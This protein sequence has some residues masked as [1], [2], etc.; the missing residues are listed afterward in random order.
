MDLY[1]MMMICYDDIYEGVEVFF[2]K[3]DLKNIFGEVLVE[4]GKI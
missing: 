2:M 4:V 3:E 1:Y